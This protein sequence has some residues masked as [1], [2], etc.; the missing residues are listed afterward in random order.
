MSHALICLSATVLALGWA[1]A[2]DACCLLKCWGKSRPAAAAAVVPEYAVAYLK[3][4]SVGSE[5]V[6]S[7][8]LGTPLNVGGDVVIVIEGSPPCVDP[9]SVD[10]VVESAVVRNMKVLES[11]QYGVVCRYKLVIPA[12]TFQPG[13]TYTIYARIGTL[14]S[15]PLTVTTQ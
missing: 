7:G 6:T 1:G 11:A 8:Q 13:R 9:S 2:A 4:V 5:V 15:S 12:G 14:Q 3:I 10:V